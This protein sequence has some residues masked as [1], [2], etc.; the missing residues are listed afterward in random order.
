MSN[1]PHVGE[2]RHRHLYL[3]GDLVRHLYLVVAPP[4]PAPEGRDGDGSGGDLMPQGTEPV[5]K[6]EVWDATKIGGRDDDGVC[7]GPLVG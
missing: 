6:L 5:S 7:L 1:T 4:L 2:H 3:V